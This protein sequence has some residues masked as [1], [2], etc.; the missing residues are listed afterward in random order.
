MNRALLSLVLL[1]AACGDNGSG[2]LELEEG[3]QPLLGGYH[4]TLPYPSDYFRVEDSTMASGYRIETTGAASLMA[5]I[6][7]SADVHTTLAVDGF[8]HIPSIVAVLPDAVTDAGLAVITGPTEASVA[9]DARTI[10]LGE[11]GEPVPHYVDVDPR[12][13]DPMRRGIVIHPVVGLEPGGRYIVA[14]RGI[15][16]EGGGAAAPAEGFRRLRDGDASGEE[17]LEALVD[18]F[19]TDIFA[20][21]A[22]AG[23][24]RDDLQLA[25]DFTVG[26]HEAVVADMLRVRELTLE[27]LEEN[28]PE[29]TITDVVMD[30]ADNVAFQ[31]IGTISAPLFDEEDEPGSMLHRGSDGQVALNG[32]ASFRFRAQVPTSVFEGADPGGALCIGH[33]FFGRSDEVEHG[34]ARNIS[35]S[36]GVVTFAINWA[37]MSSDDTPSVLTNLSGHPAHTVDFGDR[38]HQ[39]MANW[40]VFTHAI[41]G[42]LLEQE[43]LQREGGEPFYDPAVL[44]YLGMSQGAILGGTMAALDPD[45]DRVVLQVGGAGFTHM[46]FRAAPF[47]PFLTVISGILDDPLDHQLFAAEM[48]VAFDRF[49]PGSYARYLVAEPLEGTPEDRALL[50]QMGIGDLSVPNLGTF[51]HA[52]LVGVPYTT[53]SPIEPYGLEAVEPPVEGGPALTIWD[54]GIDP[55]VY[56]QAQPAEEEN[57]VHEGVRNEATAIEQLRAFYTTGVVEH[58]CDGPCDTD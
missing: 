19:E 39:G 58:P 35:D 16:H 10:I 23:W 34:W 38:I 47:S 41:R 25:W 43:E 52:R 48:Q 28:E 32:D 6:G 7:E 30:P 33:G 26:T 36:L 20:P 37:G 50:M 55:D 22:E 53:P 56:A 21:L 12:A 24:A 11:D 40:I 54:Y 2:S 45:L 3:C 14:L 44:T 9:A 31:V 1:A 13:D 15:E 18:H 27:W 46:M 17:S 42:G 29:I 57:P 49:D 5:N 8:S 51:L 4:C